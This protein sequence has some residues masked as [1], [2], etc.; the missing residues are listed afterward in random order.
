MYFD[1]RCFK[2]DL[3]IR[4]NSKKTLSLKW[5]NSNGNAY[6][7][8]GFD[9]IKK[10]NKTEKKFH[11]TGVYFFIIYTQLYYKKL[12]T[13][14]SFRMLKFQTLKVI[15]RYLILSQFAVPEIFKGKHLLN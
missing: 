5:F 9:W 6:N 2:Q 15:D 7:I 13:D 14:N 3:I 1:F 8:L 4:R 12:G 11:N 10:E